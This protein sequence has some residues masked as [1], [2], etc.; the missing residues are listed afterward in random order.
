MVE[1]KVLAGTIF[2]LYNRRPDPEQLSK[3]MIRLPAPVVVS[4][5]IVE[6][7]DVCVIG[8]GA[9]GA[10]I[11]SKLAQKGRSVILLEKGGCYYGEDMNQREVDMF[12][13]LWKN[14]GAQF[15]DNLSMAVGQGQC[16]GG[17]TV[18]NGAVCFRTP[19]PIM[20][21]WK[22]KK[23]NIEKERWNSAIDEV[24]DAIN[25]TQVQPHELNKNNRILMD[26]CNNKRYKGSPNY[27]NCKYCKQC[28]FCFLGCH[29]N[30]KQD[31]TVTYIRKALNE[32]N[33]RIYCDCQAERIT[34]SCE[35]GVV[36]GVEGSFVDRDGNAKFKIRVNAKVAVVSAGAIASSQILLKNNIAAD[37]VGRGLTFHPS[38]FLLGRFDD[39]IRGHE[40]IPM[41]YSCYEFGI[42]NGVREGGFVIESIFLPI[43]NFSVG[44][45]NLHFDKTV[46]W[47]M[48]D[49]NHYA[50]AGVFVRDNCPSG[51]VYLD[52]GVAKVSFSLKGKDVDDMASGLEELAGLWFDAGANW[53]IT[54]HLDVPMLKNRSEIREL[55]RA[56][57]EHPEKLS[58]AS[59]HPQGG[60]RMGD[61]SKECVVDSDCKVHG[62]SNLFVCD[63]S[64]F[65]SAVGVNPQITVMAIAAMTADYIEDNWTEVA[66]M[67]A[68]KMGEACSI[69][70]PMYCSAKTLDVMFR[71]A[72]G[73]L[74][75]DKIVNS[76][77]SWKIDENNLM[78][79]NDN[80]WLGFVPVDPQYGFLR[81]FGGFWKRFYKD[82]S[83]V[84]G[85]VHVMV[86]ELLDP[87]NLVNLNVPFTAGLADHPK[88]GSVIHLK[89]DQGGIRAVYD[90]LKIAD[91][92]TILGKTFVG[93]Y[94]QGVQVMEFCLSRKYGI[95]FMTEEDHKTIFKKFS[96]PSSNQA[97]GRWRIKLLS[98][99]VPDI[100]IMD[101]DIT[102]QN[103]NNLRLEDI[104]SKALVGVHSDHDIFDLTSWEAEL[105]LVNCT[106][107]VL[108]WHS[109]L[110]QSIIDLPARFLDV[111]DV[112]GGKCACMRFLLKRQG[113][114]HQ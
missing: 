95:D 89:Y 83:A 1:V 43:F 28:G 81:A 5:D 103:L 24:W 39:E 31:M 49:Y 26:I 77:K 45:P 106:C 12:S 35:K 23:V 40:G 16:L 51:S 91:E 29:Y 46:Q 75:L 18:I 66:K 50:M 86:E 21:E 113:P 101:I 19:E 64:V 82:G 8:S 97:V 84:K 112:Q 53:V 6:N 79:H 41:G 63:A 34:H 57:R 48:S 111:E 36:D 99:A 110:V 2:S 56:V 88:Y 92:N 98:D 70:Q 93:K 74:S 67:P 85:E 90:I 73:G 11:A 10:I 7:A 13:L 76:S 47:L 71:R 59:V 22:E 104:F 65:P 94:P 109:P 25:V 58:L 114:P 78:I 55:V 42:L 107:I 33:I 38:S 60:N 30:T 108:K 72:N 68:A 9:A 69:E 32:S 17:S 61:D 3:W 87:L 44:I 37:R 96:P 100:D 20:D 80:R 105:R 102:P 52:G 27:R 14:A 15:T 62:F 54:G 4:H